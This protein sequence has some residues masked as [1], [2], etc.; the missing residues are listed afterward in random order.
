MDFGYW[1]YPDGRTA[2]QQQ[3]FQSVEI[4]PQ[5][6]ELLFSM[7]CSYPFRVSIDNLNSV[8]QSG[9]TAANDEQMFAQKVYQQALEFLRQGLPERPQVFLN[10]LGDYYSTNTISAELTARLKLYAR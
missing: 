7:A 2:S 9:E 8:E 10:A 4:K 6:L 3:Q 1:Y 5:A